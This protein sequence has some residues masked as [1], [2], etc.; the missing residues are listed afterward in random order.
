[1]RNDG[2]YVSPSN[3]TSPSTRFSST[4]HRCCGEM[5]NMVVQ[6]QPGS[7]RVMGLLPCGGEFHSPAIQHGGGR[8]SFFEVYEH[9]VRVFP[10]AVK[11]D[12]FA[13]GGDVKRQHGGGILQVG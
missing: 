4:Q 2:S 6:T 5:R 9:K 8:D 1:M 12:V 3:S 13:V 10:Q 11:N 7:S